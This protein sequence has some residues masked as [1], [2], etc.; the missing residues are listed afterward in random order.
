M[1]GADVSVR[2][3]PT[4]RPEL[5]RVRSRRHRHLPKRTLLDDGTCT[6]AARP[7]VRAGWCGCARLRGRGDRGDGRPVP[8][9]VHCVDPQTI[10]LA[11]RET[12]EDRRRPGRAADA[13]RA[14]I[15]PVGRHARIVSRGGPRQR[16]AG[17]RRGTDSEAV[18]LARCDGV[19]G[20]RGRGEQR[21]DET[22]SVA[23]GVGG[24][25]AYVV[26]TSTRQPGDRG[27]RLAR[28]SDPQAPDIH[29]VADHPEVVGR[30][31]PHEQDR[32]RRRSCK[33]YP[34][35]CARRRAVGTRGGGDGRRRHRRTVPCGVED[36]DADRIPGTARETRKRILR[37][38]RCAPQ[39]AVEVNAVAGDPDVVA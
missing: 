29:A 10:R 24:I 4:R 3:D 11:A 39:T 32:R 17:R 1:N 38:A 12:V 25:D 36:I 16:E 13:R 30:R 27:S 2:D 31:L 34:D 6:E 33:P 7:T 26:G 22:G 18:R 28:G 19:T 5:D 21:P 14:E 9:S 35:R 15:E 20:A 8:C 37:V 23:G